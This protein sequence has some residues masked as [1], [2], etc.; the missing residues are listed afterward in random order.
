MA[1]D[2]AHPVDASGHFQLRV[3]VPFP[4][5]V[6]PRPVVEATGNA[7]CHHILSSLMDKLCKS[8][9]RDHY[10]WAQQLSQQ[11]LEEQRAKVA[12]VR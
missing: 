9:V 4:L 1:T 12:V 2:M 3:D 10:A 6:T 5:N 8:I 11:Q 7:A